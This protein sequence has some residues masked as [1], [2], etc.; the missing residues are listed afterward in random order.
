MSDPV[1]RARLQFQSCESLEG[2]MFGAEMQGST[3]CLVMAREFG[4]GQMAAHKSRIHYRDWS[5]SKF[6]AGPTMKA[7]AK[8]VRSMIVK[9][10]EGGS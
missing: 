3:L 4:D 2:M 5:D 1:E 6:D 7:S 10:G 9:R 8:L